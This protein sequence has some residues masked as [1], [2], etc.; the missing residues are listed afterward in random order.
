M[1]A[2][3]PTVRPHRVHDDVARRR[4]SSAR[5]RRRRA[6]RPLLAPPAPPLRPGGRRVGHP[7]GEGEV[8]TGAV[9]VGVALVGRG[10]QRAVD[11]EERRHTGVVEH[12][13]R[14]PA[15]RDL[16][17]VDHD[18]GPVQ[19]RQGRDVVSVPHPSLDDGLVE[20]SRP[21][22]G[23][24]GVDDGQ[25]GIRAGPRR[26]RRGPRAR[27]GRPARSS[28]PTRR[29][30][31]GEAPP[32]WR[33]AAGRGGTPRAPRRTRRTNRPDDLRR[34][35]TGCSR[36]WASVMT[37]SVPSDPTKSCDRSGP[38]AAR[39]PEPPVLI[40]APVGQR[41]LEPGDHVLDLAVAGGVLARTPTRHPTTH[42]REVHRLGP[43][44]E[45]DVLGPQPGLE[46]GPEGPGQHV[47]QQ[48]R[49]V[50]VDDAGQ[51]AEIERHPAEDRDA[52]PAHPGPAGD[53][54]H[55]H[56]AVVTRGR[57]P[58]RPVG[59]R[60]AG[61]PRRGAPGPIPGW[62]TGWRAAT[63]LV[64]PRHGP[65]RRASPPRTRRAGDRAGRRRRE[66]GGRGGGRSPRPRARRWV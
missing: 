10:G 41:H 18:P 3:G 54:R 19:R 21:G 52:R 9:D 30:R 23:A 5:P 16:D 43:V 62:P 36:S 38:S 4:C 22:R 59:R 35:A 25:R 63:S 8:Q 46:V 53:G 49:G 17:G 13:Q 45:R 11:A 57:A 2:D 15:R 26:P 14:R 34:G 58:R 55:R 60:W 65:R 61:P 31:R 28:G 44:P 20:R 51:A 66:R 24:L 39:G 32:A 47:G 64:R 42:R 50:D 7:S 1:V 6:C 40:D 33:R 29:G 27:T 12:R 56:P 48:R 37:P